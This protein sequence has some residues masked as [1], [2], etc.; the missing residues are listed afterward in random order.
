MESRDSTSFWKVINDFKNS[1]SSVSD[2]SSNIAPDAWFQYFNGLMNAKDVN[3]SSIPEGTCTSPSF[4][5]EF[6][7]PIT[8][9]EV[10]TGIKSLKNNTSVGYDCISNEM[11]KYSSSSMIESI[12]KLF[13]LIY[14]AGYYPTQWSESMIKP[15]FKSGSENDPS[16]YRGI[17]ISSCLSKLFSRILYNHLDTYIGDKD[18]L[19][20]NQI[21]FR[22]SFRPSDHVYTLKSM[23][24][25]SF[26]NKTYLYTCFVDLRKAFDTVWREALFQKLLRY[27]VCGKLFN[28][29]K[30]M[31][32]EVTYSVKLQSG[33]TDP[34]SSNI[35]VKQGCILSP[36]L[37]NLFVNDLP[38][39]FETEKCEPIALGDH[40]VNCLMYADDIV[41]LSNSKEGLQNSLSNL[42]E[43]CDSWNLKINIEKTKIIIFN[44]SGKLL[45]NYGFY[46]ND[47]Q[48]ENV[49]EYKYLGILM[50]ASGTFTNAIQYLSNKALKVI[51]MIRRRFQTETINAKLFLKLFDTCVKPILL[52]G[53]ESWSVFNINIC[54]NCTDAS[55][56]SL[57][58]QYENFLPEKVHT[59]FCKFILGVN[60]Y[61]SNLAPKADLGRYPLI[62]FALLQSVKYWLY[63]NENPFE[64]CNRYSYLSQIHLDGSAASTFNHHISSLLKYFGFN[65]VWDNKTTLSVPRLI[66]ALK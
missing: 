58:K 38:N 40:L 47:I 33:L 29:I 11:L 32:S 49:Q 52:Y 3:E 35:G 39:C 42:K 21:G 26:R 10:K 15:L 59:R 57:E 66:H 62:I 7:E 65:H 34:F 13:N 45:K 14:E 9:K 54:R 19:V 28:I 64:K 24:D 55:Q 5:N 8:L 61:T 18:I 50:R 41:L 48:L 30:A 23:I 36:L 63:L 56:F 27:G 16:N 20:D 1:D 25:K 51:F 4:V 17:S 6:S 31:Y 22:K 2:Q 43:F 53:S 12:C 44:K 46:I 60:K 37:F